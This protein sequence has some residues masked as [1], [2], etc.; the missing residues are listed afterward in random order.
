MKSETRIVGRVVCFFLL[1]RF[2]ALTTTTT[3]TACAHR[4]A[5]LLLLLLL[6]GSFG[7]VG[8]TVDT[9][10]FSRLLLLVARARFF[11]FSRLSQKSCCDGRDGVSPTRGYFAK[12]SFVWARGRGCVKDG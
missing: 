9:P 11:N 4:D 6:V 10:L 2:L 1:F 12:D 7:L 8:D 5:L 3:T